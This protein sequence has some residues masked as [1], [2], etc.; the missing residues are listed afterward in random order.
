[1]DSAKSVSAETAISVTRPSAFFFRLQPA[2]SRAATD[3]ASS[4]VMADCFASCSFDEGPVDCSQPVETNIRI[5]ILNKPHRLA[6]KF[7][8]RTVLPNRIRQRDPA[9]YCDSLPF[10]MVQR[11][12]SF[13]WSIVCGCH[14]YGNRLIR[15]WSRRIN[16]VHESGST[17]AVSQF[18]R[19]IVL[20]RRLR[21]H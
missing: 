6:K 21:V 4:G 12:V 8:T 20:T 9:E 7:I 17:Q 13:P 16:S 19:R 2:F 10:A 1:M 18:M 3:A 15:V 5:T 14:A 11:F